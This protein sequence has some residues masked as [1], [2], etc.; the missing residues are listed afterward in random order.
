MKAIATSVAILTGNSKAAFGGTKL[1]STTVATRSM[2]NV[3]GRKRER[4]LGMVAGICLDSRSFGM[5][6][7]TVSVIIFCDDRDL[8]SRSARDLPRCRRERIVLGSRAA[9][10][11]APV[12]GEPAG[13]P[14]RSGDTPALVRSRHP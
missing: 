6:S 4:V 14:A 12:D 7:L 9:P 5:T 2:V 3:S 1:A 13:A 11:L 10:R 8:R